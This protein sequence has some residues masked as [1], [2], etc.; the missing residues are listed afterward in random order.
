MATPGAHPLIPHRG[1]S[2]HSPVSRGGFYFFLHPMPV[3]HAPALSLLRPA[4][5]L[6]GARV[7]LFRQAMTKSP[8]VDTAAKLQRA[9]ER[10][11][12]LCQLGGWGIFLTSQLAFSRAFADPA[13]PPHDELTDGAISVY[14]VLLGL[15][16]T[17]YARSFLTR[18]GWKE[19]GWGALLPRGL[20]M[21][22]GLSFLWNVIGF[23]YT[24]G[25]LGL[26]W[27]SKYSLG[28][29][30]LISWINGTGLIAVWMCLYFF[31]HIFE[32]LNR[33]QIE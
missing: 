11:Y 21:A 3:E 16:L 14:V 33:L 17:H 29:I 27:T 20:L 10:L 15:V 24:H 2:S 22:I 4:D 6:A 13:A 9:K 5:G 1:R 8:A 23:G 28:L 19:L 25:L 26:P 18:W 30:C 7:G 12:V 32:R 31:Y